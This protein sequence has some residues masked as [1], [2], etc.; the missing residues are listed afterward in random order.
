MEIDANEDKDTGLEARFY[1]TEDDCVRAG[2]ESVPCSNEKILTLS[3]NICLLGQISELRHSPSSGK[4]RNADLYVPDFDPSSR[5]GQPLPDF[6]LYV[7][8]ALSLDDLDL[9]LSEFVNMRAP[10]SPYPIVR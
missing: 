1:K 2:N 6:D 4:K 5:S 7:S 8:T 3:Y 9:P 10:P